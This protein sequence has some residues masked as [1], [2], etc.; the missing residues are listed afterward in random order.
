MSR[1]KVVSCPGCGAQ[2]EWGPASV[3]RPFCSNRCEMSDLGAWATEQYRVAGTD[4]D[5]LKGDE[6]TP[7]KPGAN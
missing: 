5:R 2:V 1:A 3:F 4:A 6:Q 7:T